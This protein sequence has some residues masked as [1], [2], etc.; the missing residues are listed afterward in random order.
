M[1]QTKHFTIVNSDKRHLQS[2]NQFG[3]CLFSPLNRDGL[4]FCTRCVAGGAQLMSHQL[5]GSTWAG[6]PVYQ[7]FTGSFQEIQHLAVIAGRPAGS[8]HCAAY[9]LWSS[10]FLFLFLQLD[11]ALELSSASQMNNPK[12][13]KGYLGHKK[14]QRYEEGKVQCNQRGKKVE[15]CA[16]RMKEVVTQGLDE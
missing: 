15:V 1:R 3:W 12:H 2:A 6:S 13:T 8:P 10:I 16:A 5:T 11:P 14:R 4:S 9:F 7:R